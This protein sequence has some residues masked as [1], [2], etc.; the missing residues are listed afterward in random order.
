MSVHCPLGFDEKWP[1]RCY[2][3][4]IREGLEVKEI[5]LYIPSPQHARH[6]LI[7]ENV[8]YLL[9][10][11]G[12]IKVVELSKDPKDLLTNVAK[13]SAI[14]SKSKKGV[15]CLS[16]GMRSLAIAL[17]L[18][19]LSLGLEAIKDYSVY[20]EVEGEPEYY[21]LIPLSKLAL[22]VLELTDKSDLRKGIIA[23]LMELGEARRIDIKR[24][25][26]EMGIKYSKQWV[27]QTIEEMVRKGLIE[28]VNKDG[29]ELLRL[30]VR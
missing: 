12:V 8:K 24:K 15:L 7:L 19:S 3:A 10:D 11:K 16:G 18:A 1:L 5:Y 23:V 21:A 22:F 2:L 30:K 4:A 28:V 25:L 27:Y 6:S 17:L 9:A 26:D 14:L 20:L 29:K 13:I